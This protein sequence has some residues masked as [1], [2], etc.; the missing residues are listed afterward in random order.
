MLGVNCPVVWPWPCS[1]LPP[2]LPPPL[3]L[4]PTHLP[5]SALQ[6]KCMGEAVSGAATKWPGAVLDLSAKDH[7]FHRP[8]RC[9][10]DQAQSVGAQPSGLHAFNLTA[11]SIPGAPSWSKT[12]GHSA[13]SSY[14]LPS[15]FAC[16]SI[17]Q[18]AFLYK[19]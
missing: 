8:E 3:S 15:I 7:R 16:S 6:K 5:P 19:L 18:S 11:V 1:C 10:R 13:P 4:Y 12:W 2:A 17:Q 14:V 9:M